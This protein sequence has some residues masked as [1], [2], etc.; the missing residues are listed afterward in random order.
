MDKIV[1][2]AVAGSGK[3]S[4]IVN[5]L[6]ENSQ[7]L[8]ITYTN[9]NLNNLK[10]KIVKKFDFFP[11][12]ICLLSYFTF[13]YQF[14][15]KPF[16][17]RKTGVT[18]ISWQQPR[19][20]RIRQDNPMYYMDKNRRLYHNRIAKLL[21]VSDLFTSINQRIEK[22]FDNVYIDEVQDFGGN[23]FNLLKSIFRTNVNLLLVGDFYQHTYDTSRDAN[24]NRNLHNDINAY[25]KV[26]EDNGI[27]IDKTTLN[28]SW[29]CSPDI[30]NFVSNNLG[31]AMESHRTDSSTISYATLKDELDRII[32]CE[33]TV[34]LFYQ[35]HYSFNCYSKNWGDSKGID[36]YDDVC[37]VLNKTTEKLFK[38]KEL[39]KL[40]PLTRNK[41]YVACTRARGNLHFISESSLR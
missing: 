10:R 14:C 40:N 31:I 38:N 11:Q 36:K 13:L 41:F 23:D 7:S 3:T 2:F 37:V 33:K 35:K 27:F 21:E 15:F 9:S 1:I 32:M 18:G 25:I 12:C 28:K 30:C 39:H 8:V 29:R 34:K 17:W 16:L 5:N 19:I 22:Y 4:H 26:F 20:F 24:V 6:S